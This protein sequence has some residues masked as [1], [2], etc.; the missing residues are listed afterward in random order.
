MHRN[1]ESWRFFLLG[2]TICVRLVMKFCRL[3]RRNTTMSPRVSQHPV[4]TLFQRI[5]LYSCYILVSKNVLRSTSRV[6]A[7]LQQG[8]C[9][10]QN[11]ADEGLEDR[12]WNRLSEELP[13]HTWIVYILFL[14]HLVLGFSYNPEQMYFM[15]SKIIS[16]SVQLYFVARC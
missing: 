3:E 13:L 12:K 4:P 5:A 14:K 9:S 16:T 6:M 10:L 8:H 7:S 11:A 2:V 15:K 1:A